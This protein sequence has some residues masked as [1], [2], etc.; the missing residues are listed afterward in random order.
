V[1]EAKEATPK[2]QL[3]PNMQWYKG[4]VVP[5][6]LY[7]Y[8]TLNGLIG[9]IE[10]REI[11]ATNIFYLND[12]SEFLYAT[13]VAE[14][15]LR[16]VSVAFIEAGMLEKIRAELLRWSEQDDPIHRT[17]TYV[18]CFSEE[19]DLLS[20]WRGYCPSGGVSI[21]FDFLT[22]LKDLPYVG[23]V[24][25]PGIL[26]GCFYDE[27]EQRERLIYA[28]QNPFL[29]PTQLPDRQAYIPYVT[30]L[31]SEM[32]TMKHPSF[33]EEKEWRLTFHRP[34]NSTNTPLK[35]R[36]RADGLIPYTTVSLEAPDKPYP[37]GIREVVIAGSPNQNLIYRSV[38]ALLGKHEINAEV[39]PSKIPF[40]NW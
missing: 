37:L 2:P 14:N 1:D 5:I 9:I 20:Q 18:S 30:R 28:L 26:R 15:L 29:V 33:H 13:S 19:G 34:L 12:L 24:K 31:V 36:V 16:S 8:T 10:N 22:L 7:H 11:W 4:H 27:A 38:R 3:P 32:V 35:F 39:R 25:D 21:G 40:R 23:R 17:E 6:L